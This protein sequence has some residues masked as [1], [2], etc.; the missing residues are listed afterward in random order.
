MDEI[1][2]GLQILAR[3]CQDRDFSACQDQVWCGE[4]T[5]AITDS[6]RDILDENGWFVDE[7]FDCW[8]HFC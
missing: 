4:N 5:P 8:S 1:L 3:R 7:E 2:N 6:E